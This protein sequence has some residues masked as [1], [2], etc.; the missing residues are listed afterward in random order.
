MDVD[1]DRSGQAREG[2]PGAEGAPRHPVTPERAGVPLAAALAIS[3]AAGSLVTVTAAGVTGLLPLVTVPPLESALLWSRG[4]RSAAELQLAARDGLLGTVALLL[5][6]AFLV[7]TVAAATLLLSRG[8]G[9]GREMAVRGALGATP[10]RLLRTLGRRTVLPLLATALPLGTVLGAL[11]AGA[12]RRTWPGWPTPAPWGAPGGATSSATPGIAFGTAE[13]AAL[14]GLALAACLGACLLPARRGWS[15]LLASLAAGRRSTAPRSEGGLRRIVSTLQLAACLV[16]L[17]ASALL[18]RSLGPVG[19]PHPLPGDEA[20]LLPLR[21]APGTTE[22]ELAEA[23]GTLLERIGRL[24]TFSSE[25]IA[26][27]GAWLDLGTVDVVVA[28]CGRC[29]R[30][31]LPLPMLGEQARHHLVTAGFFEAAGLPALAGRLLSPDDGPGAPPVAVVSRSFAEANFE[32]GDP[33]GRNL[34]V[35]PGPEGWHEVVGVVEDRN[36]RVLGRS[37]GRQPTVYLSALQ[38][39][40]AR[41]QLAAVGGDDGEDGIVALLAEIR[42]AGLVSDGTPTRVGELRRAQAAPLPWAG[43]AAALA[44]AVALALALWGVVLAARV[45]VRARRSELGVRAA[46]GAGPG[47]L[48]RWVAWRATGPA[49]LGVLLS[50]PPAVAVGGRLRELEGGLPLL[51]LP[52]FMALAGALVLAVALASLGAASEALRVSPAEALADE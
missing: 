39:P 21:A 14:A 20:L 27:P 16:L 8:A 32:G 12:L 6:G 19:G 51:D 7:A 3:C 46:L 45:E 38:H 18:L 25:S 47:R 17:S 13:T 9:L 33:L 2:S 48:R 30:G 35:G 15:G 1:V 34:R 50:I 4:A 26:S 42:R 43:G 52:V 41:A 40:P 5:L 28:Q 49:L 22:G 23:Y 44:G 37:A 10:G 24:S 11:A 31:G 36:E 29:V